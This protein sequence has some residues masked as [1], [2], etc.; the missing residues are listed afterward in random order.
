MAHQVG[1]LTTKQ[2]VA[3]VAGGK[4]PLLVSGTNIKTVN[5]T[6]LLGSGNIAISGGGGNAV[7]V[8]V[9]FGA[10]FT[11]KAQTVVTGQAWVEADSKIV[12]SVLCPAGSD[13][14]E[15]YLLNLRPTIS[16][17]VAGDGFTVTVYSEPQASG[18]YTVNCIGV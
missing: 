6:S 14:D 1:K 15:M 12:A 7:A 3:T 9:A 13:P 2:S 17:L 10:G 16:D 4:Q 8:T 18:N 11:D 5:G